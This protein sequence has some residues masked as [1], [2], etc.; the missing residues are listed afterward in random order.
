MRMRKFGKRVRVDS[1]SVQG[2]VTGGEGQH[3]MV[4]H[5]ILQKRASV[6]ITGDCKNEKSMPHTTRLICLASH[7]KK[8]VTTWAN[9]VVHAAR[10][11]PGLAQKDCTR[12]INRDE[13]SFSMRYNVGSIRSIGGFEEFCL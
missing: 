11:V 9:S 12:S 7:I 5:I 6:G 10:N 2:C 1:S 3:R 4:H 13:L 8:L